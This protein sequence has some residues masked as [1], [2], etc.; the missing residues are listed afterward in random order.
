MIL[1]NDIAPSFDHPLDMLHA[2]HGKILR[3]CDT[4]KKTSIHLAQYGCDTEVQQAATNILKYFDTAGQFH[5]QDEE[6]ELFPVLRQI[7]GLDTALLDRLLTEH[8]VLLSVWDALRPSLQR[9]A[10]GDEVSLE[11]NLVEE[12]IAR[13]SAHIATENTAL[14]PMATRVL[15]PQQLAFMGQKMAERRGA[16]FY[17][18]DLARTLHKSSE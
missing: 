12:F 1:S 5:H 11:L 7:T 17:S 2:C 13:Y 6:Q 4:L 9:L 10:A 16:K 15:N 8:V 3:L 18:T 14:L